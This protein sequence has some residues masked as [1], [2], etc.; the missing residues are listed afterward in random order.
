V[1]TRNRFSTLLTVAICLLCFAL[2]IPVANAQSQQYQ[3]PAVRLD[4]RATGEAWQLM[5]GV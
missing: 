5:S 3:N 2:A 1:T 4:R